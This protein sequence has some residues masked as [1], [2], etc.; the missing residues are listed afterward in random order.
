[1]ICPIRRTQ[2]LAAFWWRF[3]G[4]LT[5]SSSVQIGL[6]DINVVDLI[7]ASS[8]R[9]GLREAVKTLSSTTGLSLGTGGRDPHQGKGNSLDSLAPVFVESIVAEW[10]VRGPHHTANVSAEPH[11]EHVLL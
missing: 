2:P 9:S 3:K 10:F 6:P 1:M 8:W 4:P 5:Q 11:Q 7:L